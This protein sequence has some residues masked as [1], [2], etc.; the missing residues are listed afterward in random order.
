L[1]RINESFSAF[2]IFS[3]VRLIKLPN[4]FIVTKIT[5]FFY[6]SLH[7]TRTQSIILT[8]IKRNV[9]GD[10]N[11]RH[12]NQQ[13][14]KNMEEEYGRTAMPVNLEAKLAGGLYGLLIGDALGVPYEFH[15]PQ[16]IPPTAALEFEPPAA[17]RRAHATVPPGTWSDDGAQALALLASLLDCGELNL[18]DFAAK[19]VNWYDRGDLAVD[20]QVFDVGIQTRIAI[21]KLK[22]GVPPHLAGGKGERGNG[23]MATGL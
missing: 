8:N 18:Q 13:W 7:C 22:D 6:K 23:T 1:I 11:P 15:A 20:N 19:L 5:D 9:R 2:P 21:Q 16:E 10:V 14:K 3:R 4:V 17:F 12:I